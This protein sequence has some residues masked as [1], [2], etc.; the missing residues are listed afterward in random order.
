MAPNGATGAQYETT[1]VTTNPEAATQNDL[2]QVAY[3][4]PQSYALS[5]WTPSAPGSTTG[6]AVEV[7][8]R[9]TIYSAPV[10][11]NNYGQMLA[12]TSPGKLALWTPDTPNG[13]MGSLTDISMPGPVMPGG[14]IPAAYLNAIALNNYGQALIVG[15]RRVYLFQPATANERSGI[16]WS[17]RYRRVANISTPRTSMTGAR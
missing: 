13:T 7:T 16:L 4:N 8:A 17:G 14:V 2:G 6:Q 1:G 10:A 11:I 5:I 15:E 3:W 9:H 12:P